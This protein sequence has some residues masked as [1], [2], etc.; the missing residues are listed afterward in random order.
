MNK[1]VAP[2]WGKKLVNGVKSRN[3][4]ALVV[5]EMKN[6]PKP[7]KVAGGVRCATL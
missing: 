5:T 3:G 4:D 7:R 6:A 1:L 2:D